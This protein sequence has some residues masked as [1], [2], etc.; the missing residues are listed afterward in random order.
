M[1]FIYCDYKLYRIYTWL[2]T[3]TL[4]RAWTLT[5]CLKI[6]ANDSEKVCGAISLYKKMNMH[7][8]IA[9]IR[10]AYRNPECRG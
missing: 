4:E 3:A 7:L 9:K 1:V 10:F 6:T 2:V 5:G 8:M